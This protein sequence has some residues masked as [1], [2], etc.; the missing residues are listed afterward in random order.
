MLTDLGFGCRWVPPDR[1]VVRAP[2][3]RTD[4]NIAD[5]VVEELAR[6][7]GYDRIESVPLVGRHPGAGPDAGAQPARTPA[8]RRRRRRPAGGHHLPAD[9]AGVCWPASSPPSML[10]MHP[11]L[12]LENP[13]NVEQSVMRTSLRASI[14]QTCRPTCGTSAAPS[15]CSSAPASSSRA[16]D[17]LPEERE[18][19]VGAVGGGRSGRWGE[20]TGEPLDFYDAKGLIEET[21]ERVGANVEFRAERRIRPA[22]RPHRH[23]VRRRRASRRVRARSTRRSPRSSTSLRRPS[24]SRSTSPASPRRSRPTGAS[25]RSLASRPSAR[26]SR[27]WST[28]PCRRAR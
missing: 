27:C 18:V 28:P 23:A 26:T 1:Y 17:G 19:L 8:R 15:P 16:P 6:V 24:S 25:S 11:P 3:W 21:F 12:R 2:Y 14:L 4:V 20:P 5:D 13:M 7:G 22:A 10:E 9:L